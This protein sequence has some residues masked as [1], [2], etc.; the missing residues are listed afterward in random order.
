MEDAGHI[1]VVED[2]A[3]VQKALRAYLEAE[4]YRV[5]LVD[6]GDRMREVMGRDPADLVIMDLKLPNDDGFELTKTG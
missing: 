4:G 5:S 2:D 6:D 3:F 1:L